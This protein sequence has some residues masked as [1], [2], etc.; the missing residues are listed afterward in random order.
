MV[1]PK[2]AFRIF[3]PTFLLVTA[4]LT[5]SN[6]VM[7]QDNST[8]NW[9]MY[10]GSHNLGKGFNLHNEVQ[11]RNYNAIGDLQ[12]LMLRAGLGYN[13]TPG[14]NNILV[15]YAYIVHNPYPDV[16]GD[17]RSSFGEH[18]TWQ[19][20][21]QRQQAGR[22]LFQHR[23]RAEQRW[24]ADKEGELRL[25]YFLGLNIP[26]NKPQMDDGA[27]YLSLYN[28]I[29]LNAQPNF[30]DRNRLY[31]ALG[32]VVKKNLLRI[33]VGYMNQRLED[34]PLYATYSRPQFQIAIFN[35]LPQFF[36]NN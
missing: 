33:E 5:F 18:R 35:S 3:S 31:A 12:Q 36:N 9:L 2:S 8:G 19:Q 24:Y 23:Y 17:P 22:V 28:E 16:D 27:V 30:F 4:L 15:G 10:F 32:Y 21:I 20:F 6:S 13:L 1:Q 26:V 34:A 14:N 7:A 29:F 11:H 25:R